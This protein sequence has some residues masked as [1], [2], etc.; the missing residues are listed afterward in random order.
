MSCNKLKD[1]GNLTSVDNIRVLMLS[2]NLIEVIKPMDTFI[3]LDVLDLHDN[4][5]SKI[6]GLSKLN[7]LR[8]LNLSN[9]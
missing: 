9:N 6:D 5:I 7:Q 2:K 1:I 3:N 8:V 4:K